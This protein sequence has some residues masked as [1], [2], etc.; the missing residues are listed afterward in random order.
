MG[1]DIRHAFGAG[2]RHG[3]FGVPGRSTVSHLTTAAKT[4]VYVVAT[5]TT[6]SAQYSTMTSNAERSD[7]ASG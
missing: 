1:I 5:A 7:I 3:I 6:S 2:R 4:D